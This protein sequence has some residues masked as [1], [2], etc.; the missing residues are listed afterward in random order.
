MNL[1][2]A[3]LSNSQITCW[4]RHREKDAT[5]TEKGTAT[6]APNKPVTQ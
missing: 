4:H 5:I 6:K 2:K 1:K 3:I